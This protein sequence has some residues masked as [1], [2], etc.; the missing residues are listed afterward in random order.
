MLALFL[1]VINAAA[2]LTLALDKLRARYGG[3]RI[4]EQTLLQLALFGGSIGAVLGQQLLRHKTRK[5]PFRLQLQL[6]LIC[7]IVA[8]GYFFTNA[9]AMV[10]ST[11]SPT[12]GMP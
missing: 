1:L 5:Q 10:R 9:P 6:I 12:I 2:F 7:Q 4:P 11:L 3:W 8:I